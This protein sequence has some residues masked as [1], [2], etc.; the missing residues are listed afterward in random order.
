MKQEMSSVDIKYIVEELKSL[1]GALIDKIYHDGE[2]IRIKLRVAG[3][4]RK[5]LIIEAGR[6]IHL[7]TYIK[8]APQQP[9]SFTMLLRKYLSG[10][11]LEKIEQHDFPKVRRV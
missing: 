6:R 3:E 9:S 2:Q 7:T 5:D 8:E 1:E 4:G 10:S 11:R